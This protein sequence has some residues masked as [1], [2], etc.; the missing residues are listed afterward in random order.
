MKLPLNY[1]FLKTVLLLA[2]LGPSNASLMISQVRGGDHLL[3]SRS[4]S[5]PSDYGVRSSEGYLLVYSATDA[6]SEGD[7]VFNA[8]SSYLIYT[9]DGKFFKNIENHLSRSDE[10]P[11]LVR[12]PPGAY[13]VEARST[14]NGYV[15][16][17]V[18][19]NPGRQTILDLDQRV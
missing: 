18:V 4:R 6:V 14:N 13:S 1:S 9:S 3:V 7:M 2:S 17:R 11:E 5:E 15:R 10:I 12:L 16:V 19:I 8:H